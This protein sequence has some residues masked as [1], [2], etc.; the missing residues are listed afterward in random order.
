MPTWSGAGAQPKCP[1]DRGDGYKRKV[2]IEPEP[3]EDSLRRMS[4]LTLE[5]ISEGALELPHLERALLAERLAES[6]ESGEDSSIRQSWAQEAVRRRDGIRSGRVQSIP[7]DEALTR[8]HRAL[9][10]RG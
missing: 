10:Q 6:L 1:A 9:A 5:Q 3:R 4:P 8:V 2:L 7:G